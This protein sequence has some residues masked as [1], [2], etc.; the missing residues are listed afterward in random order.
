[1][2][3]GHTSENRVVA[4]AYLVGL[5]PGVANE[6]VHVAQCQ[7]H[8]GPPVMFVEWMGAKYFSL[9]VFYKCFISMISGGFHKE[10]GAKEV[11][12]AVAWAPAWWVLIVVNNMDSDPSVGCHRNGANEQPNVS[13]CW[14][15]ARMQ[16]QKS[17]QA[18]PISSTLSSPSEGDSGCSTNSGPRCF[19]EF[20]RQGNQS[21][22]WPDAV[23]NFF[24]YSTVSVL[25]ALET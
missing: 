21:I 1:M 14:G 22:W 18:L 11:H 4:L 3:F 5:L 2:V 19:K 15:H 8:S 25:N 9:N 20:C 23:W 16:M 12:R 6:E 13:S 10:G 17:K 7:A 24:G